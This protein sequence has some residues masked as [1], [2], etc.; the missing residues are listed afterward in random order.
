M[1]GGTTATPAYVKRAKEEAG[2]LEL[3]PANP[4]GRP[5]QP[6]EIAKAVAFLL[7]DE[8]SYVGGEVLAVTGG[9]S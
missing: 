8:S 4:L 7:S 6:V 1:T 2:F 9:H 3:M 5:A